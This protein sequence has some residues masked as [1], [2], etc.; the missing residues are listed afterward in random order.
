MSADLLGDGNVKVTFVT[1]LSSISAP[2][3]TQ[4]NA[5]VDLQE[6]I[7]KEGLNI[8]PDQA[9]VDNT[10]LASRS[11]TEDAGT[12]KHEIALTYKRKEQAVDD[13]AFNTLVPRTLG[14]LAVRRNLANET[15]WAALQEAEIYP[16]RCGTYMRQPPKLNEPQ[17]VEQKMFN[18]EA[19][20]TEA[21]VA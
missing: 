5:G 1:T 21:V 4:L 20:D 2:T 3:A 15:A 18:H 14:W 13:I 16:V 9:S 8:K 19:A 17:V 7:T 11:E 6:F 10:A 12:V